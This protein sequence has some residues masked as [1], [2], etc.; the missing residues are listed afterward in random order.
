MNPI[1]SLPSTGLWGGGG[2]ADARKLDLIVKG[3]R[4]YQVLLWNIFHI[5]QG[6]S[7]KLSYKVEMIVVVVIGLLRSIIL[8]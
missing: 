8:A 4:V 3:V 2:G 7:E 1:I 5:H 6:I